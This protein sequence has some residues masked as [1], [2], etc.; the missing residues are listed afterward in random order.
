MEE[1]EHEPELGDGGVDAGVAVGEV[2]GEEVGWGVGVGFGFPRMT[3]PPGCGDGMFATGGFGLVAG[4]STWSSF[5]QAGPATM[6]RSAQVARVTKPGVRG[7]LF[8]GGLS[9][10]LRPVPWSVDEHRIA[11]AIEAV[12]DANRLRVGGTNLV[13]PGKG[14]DEE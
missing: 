4:T 8:I 11:V 7:N 13:D 3:V 10:S 14:G 12:A 9:L 5:L 2:P 6:S 1:S